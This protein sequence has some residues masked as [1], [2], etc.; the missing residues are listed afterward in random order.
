REHPGVLRI[1]FAFKDAAELAV[2]HFKQLGLRSLAIYIP[3]DEPQTRE[4][5]I[6]PF[7]QIASATSASHTSLLC[8]ADLGTL[9]DP[10]APVKP[11]PTELANWLHSLP[12]PTGV[13][14]PYHGGG[15]YVIRC[16]Q[17]L[18]LRVPED[19]AVIGEDDMESGLASE[20]ALTTV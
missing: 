12:K 18:G 6:R 8:P 17:A 1:A 19:I 9:R 11:V 2:N 20:P 10:H 3:E 15:S 5:M 4:L 14:C 7:L 16:C 13:F